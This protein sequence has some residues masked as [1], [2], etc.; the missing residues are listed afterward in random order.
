MK[1]EAGAEALTDEQVVDRVLVGDKAMFEILM[2]RHNTRI[3][4]AIRAILRDEADVEDAMQQA[5]VNA[6]SHLEGFERRAQFSTWL[7]RIAVHE[8]IARARRRGTRMET[9]FV[10]E[11]GRDE[12]PSLAADEPTPEHRAFSGELRALLEHAIDTLPPGL[13]EVFML[14]E[15]EGLTT[16]E[17][18]ESL[19][20][21]AEAVKTR[22]HRARALLRDDLYSRTGAAAPQAF[23]FHAVRCDRVVSSVMRRLT[24]NG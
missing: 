22:L 13:R 16:A 14:R 1:V 15:V 4:R 20:L 7:T 21:S 10:D 18:A 2:R 17:A 12:G 8:A 11:D 3:Y 9:S 6:F 24:A 5:Y 23:Q 19:D